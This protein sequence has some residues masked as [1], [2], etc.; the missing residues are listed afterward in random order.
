MADTTTPALDITEV[1]GQI[2]LPERTF[3]LCLRAD[4]R[5]EWE[6]AERQHREA[7]RKVVDSLAGTNAEVR[8]AAKEAE[9]LRAE[10]ARHTIDLTL[11][12]IPTR[13]FSDLMAK[14]PPRKEKNEAGFNTETF[15]VAL[16]AACAVNP[17]MTEEQAGQ[18][19][20]SITQGQWDD[21]ANALWDLN[22]GSVDVPFSHAVSA[23][24]HH[25]RQR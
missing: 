25:T 12:A 22:K 11:R 17:A 20:D 2:R 24:L 23:T 8:K 19:V 1:L 14:H 15:G 13:R 9:R 21:L 10:M 5:A 16:L 7:E 6:Q 18:L 4:L 3:P